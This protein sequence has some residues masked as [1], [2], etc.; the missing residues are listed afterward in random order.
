[1]CAKL[2]E[3]SFCVTVF[4]HVFHLRAIVAV[5]TVADVAAVAVAGEALENRQKYNKWLHS[6]SSI[7]NRKS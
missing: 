5:P 1:M 6:I 3:T 4:P 2:N 7:F